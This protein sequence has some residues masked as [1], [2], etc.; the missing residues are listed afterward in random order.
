MI[1][2]HIEEE[3]RTILNSSLDT[4]SIIKMCEILILDKTMPKNK[5]N[6]IDKTIEQGNGQKMTVDLSKSLGY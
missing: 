1:D 5:K 6:L 2:K 4:E 3:M